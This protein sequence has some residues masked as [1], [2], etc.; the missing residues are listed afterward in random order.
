MA[1]HSRNARYWL[2]RKAKRRTGY[3]TA[4][5]AYYG[6][7]NTRASKAVVGIVLSERNPADVSEMRK[8]FSDTEDVR[9]QPEILVAILT[10]LNERRVERVVMVDGIIGCP[11]EEG[12]DYPE[13]EACPQCPYWADRD[14][15]TGE[16]LV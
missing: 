1:V 3:P 10:F 15:W 4:T 16:R 12:I 9:S 6:P 14:R 7:D 5:L 11:H 8:W 2:E 13:D